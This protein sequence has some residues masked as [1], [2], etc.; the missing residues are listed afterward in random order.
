MCHVCLRI[1]VSVF[2]DGSRKSINCWRLNMQTCVWSREVKQSWTFAANPSRVPANANKVTS[3]KVWIWGLSLSIQITI[4]TLW[5][6]IQCRYKW[7]WKTCG[8]GRAQPDT[9]RILKR[10]MFFSLPLSNYWRKKKKRTTR[11]WKVP[12]KVHV[13]G[14]KIEGRD[15]RVQ[16]S[17]EAGQ[18]D[19]QD[20][21][22]AGCLVMC[23]LPL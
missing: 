22:H 8:S 13:L 18:Y 6:T 1:K 2:P 11:G 20:Q 10:S 23:S 15:S 4:P 5:K 7:K 16:E 12:Q 9:E 19:R 3:G 21:P 14:R 17:L